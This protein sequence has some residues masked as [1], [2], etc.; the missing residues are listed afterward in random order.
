MSLELREYQQAGVRWM[1][2]KQRCILADDMG[3]GKTVQSL[4]AIE[5]QGA[6]PCLVICPASLKLNWEREANQWLPNRTV[7]VVAGGKGDIPK[8]DIVIVNYDL[9]TR[10][11]NQLLDLGHA[12]VI[13]D[14]A[15]YVKN[16]DAAR[17]KAAL[18]L[19]W[20]CWTRILLTGTP[21]LARPIELVNL[22]KVIGRLGEFGGFQAFA[23]AYCDPQDVWTGRRWVKDYRGS[24]NLGSL[25]RRLF[26]DPGIMLR[27]TK[28]DVLPELPSTQH[29]YMP[30]EIENRSEYKRCEDDLRAYMLTQAMLDPD[31]DDKER[32]RKAMVA[33]AREGTADTL[34]RI[35]YLRQVAAR[36]K[37]PVAVKWL[38]DFL[39]DTDESIVV[40]AHHRDVID[41]LVQAFPDDAVTI[42]GG[43]SSRH[44]QDAVDDFQSKKKRIFIGSIQAAGVGLT[45]TAASNCMFLEFPWSP[46]DM[47]QATDRINRMGQEAT[48][49]TAHLMVGTDT[50]DEAILELLEAKANV[51][52]AVMGGA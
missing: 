49:V 40:F 29:H 19:A 6:Y 7:T 26:N 22:L 43:D 38:K 16:K 1:T 13:M 24:S 41:A 23:D 8:A 48:S 33:M 52:D 11:K 30:V 17:S 15:H 18:D 3:T 28:K 12:S 9:L 25:N 10:R 44:R 51:V 14:E 34:V 42:R 47:R 37:V 5:A 36:G 45:L 32:E 21:L 50:I 35:E 20:K 27:R 46:S 4:M 2:E 39:E 31:M